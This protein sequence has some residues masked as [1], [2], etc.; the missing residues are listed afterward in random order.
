MSRIQLAYPKMP[1]SKDAPLGHCIAF[2]KYDGTNLHWVWERELGWYAFGTRRDRFDLDASGINEFNVAH[3][4]LEEASSL[5]IESFAEP[6]TKALQEHGH[7]ES[8]Q[9]IAFTEF[10]GPNSFAGRHKSVD[11]KQLVLIDV[12]TD[13]QFVAPQTFVKQFE[14]LPIA[15]VIYQGKLTGKFATAV[16]E[17]EYGVAEG[18]VCK[19][20]TQGSSQKMGSKG[21][22]W[23]VKIKT[24]A[25][26][27]R[28]KDLFA[29]NWES[30]WSDQN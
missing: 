14:G 26:M 13:H 3:P 25:Y 17:G 27:K 8:S 30:H 10:L 12:Q 29:N 19:G 4:G 23:M 16:R 20:V 28:L 24:N 7:L 2:K 9:V 15:E 22:V 11:P 18:V 21:Q 6:L 1:G 5:F